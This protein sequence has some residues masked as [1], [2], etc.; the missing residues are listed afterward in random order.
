MHSNEEILKFIAST[1]H[2]LGVT[3]PLTIRV[4]KILQV[5]WNQ[6]PQWDPPLDVQQFLEFIQ[7]KSDLPSY[8]NISIP[9]A[10]FRRNTKI[11]STALHM[12]TDASDYALSAVSYLKTEYVDKTVDVV[13]MMGKARVAPIKR[14]TIPN[15][16]LQAAVYGAQFALFIKKQQ[17][18]ETGNYFFWS[19][20]ITV[21]N[22][23]RNPE[24]RHRIFVGD[25]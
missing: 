23:L 16:V 1:F 25:R 20:S 12:F 13:F 19:D 18:L 4:R 15:L 24:V 5:V 11:Q 14:M 3:A 8:Q 21:L 17:D 2:P 22:W 7:F 9:R 6:G 10:L